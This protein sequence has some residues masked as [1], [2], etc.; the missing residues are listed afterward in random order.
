VYFYICNFA[1]KSKPSECVFEPGARKE[2]ILT[3]SSLCH[4]SSYFL[5]C[6]VKNRK[7]SKGLWYFLSKKIVFKSMFMYTHAK[8][9]FLLIYCS[10]A[11]VPVVRGPGRGID[12][13][14][15]SESDRRG[16]REFPGPSRSRSTG[17]C[18]GSQSRT[19]SS[20]LFRATLPK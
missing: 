1:A 9:S 15:R 14:W 18:A 5:V 20:G 10:H 11:V 17:G 12:L 6:V 13:C 2:A 16:R 8:C 19:G 7:I 3:N 4:V